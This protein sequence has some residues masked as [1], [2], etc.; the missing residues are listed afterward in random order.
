MA[1]MLCYIM[2]DATIS[3]DSLQS[4][5][6]DSVNKSFNSISVDGSESTSD[7]IVIISSNKID[8]TDI[9]EFKTALDEITEGLSRDLVRNGEGTGHVMRLKISNY[10][11]PDQQARD[12]GRSMLNNNL[13]KCAIS[14]NDPNIGRLAAS[15]G[16]FMGKI[17]VNKQD[18]VSLT[19]GERVIFR[20]GKFLLEGETIEKELSDY[21]VNAQLS[22]TEKF[23]RHQKFVDIKVDFGSSG[24]NG[25][26][27]IIGS[28]LTSEYVKINSDYRT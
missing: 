9:S 11:G 23:P 16:S 21:M 7:T 14:G 5:L 3:K 2:T 28:D 20:D 25:G 26:C 17:G 13:F 8:N 24:G 22:E 1:T 18:N 10:P 6:C 12:L 4:M 27:T 19:L 15:L